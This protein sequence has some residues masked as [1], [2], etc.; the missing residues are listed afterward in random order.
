MLKAG[1]KPLEPYKSTTTKWKC[2]HE[3]CGRIV[4]PVYA[5]VRRGQ[6]GCYEC[7]R[8]QSEKSRKMPE[9]KA[10]EIM[11]KAGLQ[12]LEPYNNAVSRWKSKCL[13]CGN[14]GFPSLNMI[15]YG[16]GGCRPCSY[17]KS[18]LKSRISK[19]EALSRLKS[20]KLR[21]VGKYQWYDKK[22]M[23][24]VLCLICKN[25]SKTN[26]DTL[27]KRGRQPGCRSCSRRAASF[28]Q[29]TEDK[30]IRLLSEHNL[31]PVGKY[32]GNQNLIVVRC[33]KCNKNK[34]IKRAFLLQRTKKMQGCMDCA[35]ARIANPS[36]IAKVMQKAKLKPL[37]PYSGGHKRWK[38]ECLKCGE[39]VYPEFN[40]ILG[41]QGGCI[42]CAEIGF[43]YREPAILYVINHVELNSIKIGITNLDSKPDR[44]K[45]FR[46][47][48]W[49]LHKR[50]EFSKGINAFKVEQSVLKWIREDRNIPQHLS[51]EAM[52]KT[53]GQ[54]ETVDA[55]LITILEIVRKTE[56]VMKG[57]RKKS[58]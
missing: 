53:G 11:L 37:V 9:K 7:G 43:N 41:G 29:V 58:L 39:V 13:K 30:H 52:P 21:M 31:D 38:C 26:W 19:S 12:P 36:K 32:T 5:S 27:Q 45:Q 57:Y 51:I 15:N 4:Y 24:T 55:D 14:V 34:K 6:G 56:Q 1:L 47:L 42:Y 8:Q 18:G 10:I 48:G 20:K 23:F 17:V 2:I 16:Q 46:S 50:Y 33:R 49:E 3:A 28:L 22:E 44:L 25:K 40:S 35:G 54:S